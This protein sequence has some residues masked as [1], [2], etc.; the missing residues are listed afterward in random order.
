MNDS[1]VYYIIFRPV[2]LLSIFFCNTLNSQV[3]YV[4]FFYSPTSFT[5]FIS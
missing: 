1:Q 4:Y 5:T 3:P 2:Y